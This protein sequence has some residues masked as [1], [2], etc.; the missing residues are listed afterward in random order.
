MSS[1]STSL[2]VTQRIDAGPIACSLTFR[3]AQPAT[4][5]PAAAAAAAAPPG[6]STA[7]MTMLV[8]TLAGSTRRP[9]SRARPSASRRAFA[10]SSASRSTI[11]SSAT[12]PA[13]ARTPAW[14]MPPPSI[15]R[16]RRARAMNSAGPQTTEPTG[17]P[18]PFETQKVTESTS[19]AKSRAGRPSATA[20]L[21]SRAPSRCTGT[22]APWATAATAAISSGVQHVPPCRLWV[23]STHTRPVWGT[24]MLEGRRASR[25]W[26]GVR[27]PRAVFTGRICT[28]PITAEPATS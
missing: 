23:F 1:A 24:W 15:L 19:R 4:S 16:T 5:S 27:K 8:C 17:A 18:R 12:R 7:T 3:A 21:K 9:G 13:A 25:T 14:R 10:W 22:A 26:S 2:C 28:L 6:R 20:A 11:R